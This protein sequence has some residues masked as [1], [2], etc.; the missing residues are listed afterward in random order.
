ML[1][2]KLACMLELKF[3]EQTVK[4]CQDNGNTRSVPASELK[5]VINYGSQDIFYAESLRTSVF[6]SHLNQNSSETGMEQV[7][8][9]TSQQRE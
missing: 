7:A 9:P 3:Q 5:S 6:Q 4:S 2:T 1:I 8:T